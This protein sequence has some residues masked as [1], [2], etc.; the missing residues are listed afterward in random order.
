MITI[1]ELT[2]N[3]CVATS[4]V[5]SMASLRRDFV[6]A[7]RRLSKSPGFVFAVIVS[8]GLGIGANATTFSIVRTFLLR[9]PAIGD[10]A[11]L[12]SVFTTQRGDC[13]GNNLSWLLYSDLRY[14]A[15][16]ISGITAFYPSL[17]TSIGGDGEAERV[18]G[19]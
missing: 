12:T 15:R 2:L 14:H 11:T 16:S 3:L 5:G 19:G 8:I 18:W 17:P 13:C 9:P 7:F 6:F 4:E 1:P 10:P